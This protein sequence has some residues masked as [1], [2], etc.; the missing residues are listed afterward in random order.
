MSPVTV[1]LGI[2]NPA[3]NVVLVGAGVP[4]TVNVL[5]LNGAPGMSVMVYREPTTGITGGTETTNVNVTTLLATVYAVI[6]NAPVPADIAAWKLGGAPG[7][8]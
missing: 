6:S 7:P 3:E 1:V 2:T 8:T 5:L 4:S